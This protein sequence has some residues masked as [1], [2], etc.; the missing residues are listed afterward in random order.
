MAYDAVEYVFTTDQRHVGVRP[1]HRACPAGL[2]T[3]ADVI[4]RFQV[5]QWSPAFGFLAEH[6]AD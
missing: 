4:S 5:R 3:E 1:P 6:L 2:Q